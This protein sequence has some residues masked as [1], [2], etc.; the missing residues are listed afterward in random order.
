[1]ANISYW[2]EAVWRAAKRG[3]R[4]AVFTG[5]SVFLVA[6]AEEPL[7]LAIAPILLLFDKLIRDWLNK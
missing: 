4:A 5:I 3:I 2:P 6:L 1:M 7:F